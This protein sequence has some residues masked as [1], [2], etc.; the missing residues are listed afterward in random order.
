MAEPAPERTGPVDWS[1]IVE[2]VRVGDQD[3]YWAGLF[4]PQPIRN[5]LLALYAFNIEL[6]RIGDMVREPALG[7]IRL[8]WWREAVALPPG[9]RTGHPVADAV[10]AVRAAHQL[11]GDLL[12]ALIDA[13]AVDIHR[14]PVDTDGALLA[15]LTQTAGSLFQL[16]CWMAGARGGNVV[17]AT[18]EA[19]LAYGLTGLMRALPVH[20]AHGRL[21]LPTTFLRAFGVEASAVLAGDETSGLRHALEVLRGRARTHLDAYRS[22]ARSLP[23]TARPVFLPLALVPVYLRALGKPA[24]RPLAEVVQVNPLGRFLRIWTAHLRG[25]V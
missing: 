22:L 15:Y 8:Q 1:A 3:R 7:E 9:E 17:A 21:Y 5:H 18:T 14:E 11:P 2:A 20:A 10:L 16:G 23:E 24:H 13:R 6:S 25:R 4:L 12:A 19:A